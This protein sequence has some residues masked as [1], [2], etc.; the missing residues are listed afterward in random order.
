MNREE[1]FKAIADIDERFI[2]ES[3]A[4]A[5]EAASGSSERTI[6]M[7]KKR[8]IT[9][10]LAAALIFLLGIAAYAT[11]FS[12]KFRFPEARETF[13]IN[14]KW[15]T[16][17][18]LDWS[19]AKLAIT[20]PDVAKSKEIEFRP[21]WL[22]E[23]MALLKDNPLKASLSFKYD[24]GWFC[25]FTAE[26]LVY[27]DSPEE[28]VPEYEGMNQPLL[29]DTYSMSQFNNGGAL[30]LLYYTPDEVIEEHWDELNVDVLRFHCTQ[31]FDAAPELNRQEYTLEQDIILLSNA[32]EGWIIRVCGQIGM[33]ELIKVAKNLEIRKTGKTFTYDD[34]EGYHY[35]IIDAAV[36]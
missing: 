20:F 15:S 21:N 2:A 16:D 17:G 23:E 1:I 27:P 28:K 25:R 13:R 26:K 8:I 5:P 31:H 9:F 32:D 22:P 7:K 24:S 35:C 19:N 18:Y 29:I 36:G 3:A 6:Y 14:Y 34:F 33:D 10:A 11:I 12:M 4:Y 30:L